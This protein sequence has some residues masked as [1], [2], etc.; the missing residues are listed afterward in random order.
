MRTIFTITNLV[1][2]SM[3]GLLALISYA[4]NGQQCISYPMDGSCPYTVQYTF[5]NLLPGET[6]GFSGDF[7]YDGPSSP[8]ANASTGIK[9]TLP[10]AAT[11]TLISPSIT[12]P[13][14]FS[15]VGFRFKVAGSAVVTS[16]DVY[17]QSVATSTMYP[18]CSNVPVFY[19]GNAFA[20]FC[21]DAPVTQAVSDLLEGTAVKLVIVFHLSGGGNQVVT[22]DDFGLFIDG[23]LIPLPV[24]FKSLTVRKASTGASLVWEVSDEMNVLH[25]EIER[26]TDGRNFTKI[27]TV[28]ASRATSYSFVDTKSSTGV[29]YYRIRSV[30]ADGKYKFS[31]V[32]SYSNGKSVVI[33]KAFPL[34]AQNTLTVQHEPIL[35]KG[36][37]TISAQDGRIMKVV[38]P[39]S[40]S[41]Q[42][43][44]DLSN[45]SRGMY[46][47]QFVNGDEQVQTLK[48]V[49][50]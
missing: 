25:Y 8:N 14:N 28:S 39:A 18:L 29:V 10:F 33:L 35:G 5:D 38:S 46:L 22:V 24:N 2:T 45:L 23:A 42:T 1:R 3:F 48:V 30:D 16:F 50:Q 27:G 12:A 13:Q 49:K 7:E 41:T 34:P 47:L 11:K 6:A 17:L 26:S 44:V 15:E 19:Q 32:V 9:S 37:I 31:T 40:G 4:S 21:M 20:E 43:L 36:Q